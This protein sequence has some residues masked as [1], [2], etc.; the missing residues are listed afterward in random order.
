MPPSW[1]LLQRQHTE[2]FPEMT[3]HKNPFINFFRKEWVLI[4]SYGTTA[5]FL[6]D[7]NFLD[8]DPG[9]IGG[10]LLFVWLFTAMLLASFAV[11]RHADVLA[12]KLK[13]PL[14]TLIL[15][16]AVT[17]I[18]VLMISSLML[19]GNNPALA[20]DTM[21]SVVMVVLGGL[22]GAALLTGGIK[23]GE[24]NFNLKGVNS[25]LGLILPLSIFSLVLPNFTRTGGDGMFSSLHACWLMFLSLIIYAVFLAVQTRF[26]R[27]FFNEAGWSPSASE[28]HESKVSV[29]RESLLLIVHLIPVILLSKQLAHLLDY[30]VHRN[31]LP[32]DLV[33]FVVAILILAPEG[34][35]AIQSAGRNHM[36]RS[37]NVLLGSVLATISLTVPAALAISLIYGKPLLLGLSPSYMLLLA[38]T[39]GS[40]IVTFGQGQ[41]NILQGFVHLLLFAAYIVLM[42]D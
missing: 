22:L 15:T 1:L 18:E 40:S 6:I 34:L 3:T 29:G 42:F 16:L 21:F 8:D 23:F 41:T 39:L 24:Q 36:Q 11:V 37:V 25:F 33:G 38:V 4:S 27:E 30:V 14:G 13:E 31:N 32:V 9:T 20:R 10:I 12:E 2:S 19:H 35:A 26:H 28:E 17:S 7:K 5:A